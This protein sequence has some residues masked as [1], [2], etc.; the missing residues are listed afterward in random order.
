MVSPLSLVVV[1]CKNGSCEHSLLGRLLL[2][3]GRA[4]GVE[5]EDFGSL[6]RTI[7]KGSALHHRPA[8]V[9][10]FVERRRVAGHNYHALHLLQNR[11][12]LTVI[13]SRHLV[14]VAFAFAD[15]GG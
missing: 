13:P 9:E 15:Y 10:F 14:A 6:K 3:R 4:G 5:P 7:C 11:G 2:E 1:R 8:G 12:K